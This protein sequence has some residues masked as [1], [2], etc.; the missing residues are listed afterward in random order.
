MSKSAHT[1]TAGVSLKTLLPAAHFH[2]AR[3][4]RVT[5]CS[6]HSAACQPGDLFVALLGAHQDGHDYIAKAVSGG[7]AAVLAEEWRPGTNVPFCV[8]E[9]SREA[10]GQVCHALAGNPAQRVPVIGVTGTNGK[11]TTS[12]LIASILHCAGEL[13]AL[14]GTLGYCDGYRTLPAPLTTPSAPLLA[15]WLARSEVRGATHAVLEVSSHA[16]AQR[17]TAGFE[18]DVACVTNVRRDHLDFHGTLANYKAAKARLFDGLRDGGVAVLNL[19]DAPCRQYLQSI[20]G[21][22]LTYGMKSDAQVTATVIERHRSEQT[23]LLSAG[24]DCVPVRTNI[25]GDHHVANCLAAATVAL[26]YNIDLDI[27]VRGLERITTMPGRL[28]RI[29]C[30]QP[31]SVFVDYAH[32]PDALTGVLAALREVCTGRLICVFGAG[33][34]RDKAKRPLMGKA[35]EAGAD[36]AIVTDD[37]PRGENPAT[38]ARQIVRGFKQPK[39]AV[40][41]HDRTT[42]IHTALAA[43]EPGDCVLLAGKGHESVQIVGSRKLLF[44]DRDVARQWLYATD[45][46]WSDAPFLRRAA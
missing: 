14:A 45:A 15:D 29:E 44:D 19:D 17:R 28:E 43:A 21:P 22:V 33:G 20:A 24:T 40:V 16:L 11:T 6:N 10:W 41:I 2:G 46:D 7:A 8:V 30:G 32:T 9:D 36:L 1:S 34:D 3:D 37:N 25:I 12:C 42:A 4:I 23:F 26:V 35:V 18:F 39:H 5:T 38:I 31:F 27:I 13:P